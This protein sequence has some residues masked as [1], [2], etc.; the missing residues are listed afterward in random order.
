MNRT[1]RSWTE[2]DLD[3]FRDNLM[4]LKKLISAD[5][6]V[7]QIVKAD[8]YGHGA[9]QIA[10]QAL[11]LGVKFLGVA[12]ADEGKLLR[13][14]GINA[15]ILILSPALPPELDM[16]F[17][18]ELI[19]TVSDLDFAE[20]ISRKA[21]EK[22]ITKKIHLN[23]DTG[24]GRSGFIMDK[25]LNDVLAVQKLPNLE[26]EG[27]YSHYASSEEDLDYTK[28][29]A[30]RF[31]QIL[32][33]LPFKPEFVHIANSSS[34]IT[35][36]D[37][38]T[39][40]VRIGLLS[41]G[42]YTNNSFTEVIDLKPA[43]T[44]RSYIAQIKTAEAGE[45]I[46]Y[47]RTYT[48]PD[49]TIYGIIPVGYADGYD[50][51]LSNCGKVKISSKLCS[52]LGKVSMDMLAVD[53]SDLPGSEVMEQ[54]ELLGGSSDEL[55]AERLVNNYRGSSYELL[56]QIGRRAKR[57]FRKQNEIFAS[58]PVLRRD[59]VSSDYSDAKLSRI[60]ESAIGERLQ[61]KEMASLI[62]KDLLEKFITDKDLDVHYRR[63]FKH[64]VEFCDHDNYNMIDY[65]A[66]NTSL[67]YSKILKNDSFYIICAGNEAAMEKY[68]QRADVEY[69]W[70]LDRSIIGHKSEFE[71]T[72]IKVNGIE[73][74]NTTRIDGDCLEVQCQDDKLLE[75]IG[76]EVEFSIST[77][78]Y[79][80]KVYNQLAV[81]ISEMTKGVEINFVFGDLL[82]DVEVIPI[83]S[84]KNKFPN[85]KKETGKLNISTKRDE[86][87]FP[88]SGVVF[89]YK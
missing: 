85:L 38:F 14:S 71:V 59:F 48:C 3:I 4:G 13:E 16:I 52:V 29:Q 64:T 39:N 83:F 7:M 28:K 33:D 5:K 86:W 58:A 36:N 47:N 61:D 19:P 88:V 41:Y 45:S 51:L 49:K 21:A 78:T 20:L 42:V 84:G 77:R 27:I 56:C 82:H 1:D 11:D 32:I 76:E 50:Y 75:L 24:M 12:N 89:V 69:R 57:Y 44:F 70:L 73:I 74:A 15:P 65:F 66:V 72:E 9:Y 55:R 35:Y 6:A 63:N 18:Y 81:Y 60:I 17:D 2:I 68:F 80:P 79:Y 31:K 40:L 8:A 53:L 67:H 43:M 10:R 26:I 62:Y 54:V 30:A 25:A 34:L 37:D 46:G 22:G 87:I 23:I